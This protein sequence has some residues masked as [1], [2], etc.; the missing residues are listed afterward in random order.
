VQLQTVPPVLVGQGLPVRQPSY[1][2]CQPPNPGEYLLLIVSQTPEN[3]ERVRRTLPPSATA[4]VCNYLDDVVTRVSG[5]TTVDTANAWARYM[6]ESIGLTAFVAR[7]AE[8]PPAPVLPLPSSQLP[9]PQP[10]PQPQ[11][12]PAQTPAPQ[13]T[14]PR[15]P[16]LAFNPQPL[17][18]GYAVL[19]DYFSQP[20]LAVQVRQLAGREI[21]LASY[22][23]R[24][25]LLAIYTA[26]P[27]IANATLQALTDRGFWAM[28]VDS[29][30]V[31]LLRQT[32][33]VSR[34]TR[35]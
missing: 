11:T 35:N 19:V 17:G 22:G 7:P 31:T 29:R 15:F 33:D 4:T 25:Y 10:S 28:V 8:T 26:D 5:F 34:L 27:A 14:A 16:S 21:G 18:A 9:Q 12:P 30:R 6:T 1:P 32:I 13:A 23:Q 2:V 24:P 3:Q 20:D